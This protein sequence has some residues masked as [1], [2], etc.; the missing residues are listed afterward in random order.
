M[1]PSLKSG[2]G[3]FVTFLISIFFYLVAAM[4]LLNDILNNVPEFGQLLAAMDSGRCPVALSGLSAVHR[5]HFAAGVYARTG[6]PVVLVCADEGEGERLARDLESLTGQRV[7]VL[8]PR[9]Y[10]FH[11]AATVSRQWE[12]RRLALMRAMAAGE[13][14]LLVAAVEG[15]LQRTLPPEELDRAWA[16]LRTGG[17]YDLNQLAE[18]LTAAG[19]SRCDQVEGVGQF[20]LR[21]G[22]LDV[23][24]PGMEQ[25]VRAEFFGDEL[26]AM[27]LFDPATQRRTENV[28]RAVLLPAAEALPHLAPGGTAGLAAR[29]EKLAAGAEKAGRHELAQTLRQDREALLKLTDLAIELREDVSLASFTAGFQLGLGIAGELTHYSFEDDEEERALRRQE[30]KE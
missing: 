11:N 13:V 25:P 1:T 24:S 29:L 8:A 7:P 9:S 5:A 26:D 27:G 30:Q 4:K 21:G 2:T 10:I 18:T 28:E 3:G 23:Y 22:I 14:P 12:H 17:S 6:R 20:A 16:E 19:Y 15:L